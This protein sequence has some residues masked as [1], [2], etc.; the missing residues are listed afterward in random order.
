L[1]VAQEVESG[2][3]LNMREIRLTLKLSGAP[4]LRVRLERQVRPYG[5]ETEKCRDLTQAMKNATPPKYEKN[6]KQANRLQAESFRKR[7]NK[8]CKTPGKLN[9]VRL[10]V[11]L[12]ST[13]SLARLT[14]ELTGAL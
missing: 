13:D 8:H 6:C 3:K 1:D 5:D 2:M 10:F 9:A 7:Q 11:G 4:F 12:N 14:P